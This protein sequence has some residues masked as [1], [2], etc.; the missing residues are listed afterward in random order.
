MEDGTN[1]PVTAANPRG[2]AENVFFDRPRLTVATFNLL[3]FFTTLRVRGAD[4]SEE[5]IRQ[6]DKLAAAIIGL[7]ADILGLVE[8]ENDADDFTIGSLVEVINSVIGDVYTAVETGTIG[9]DAIKVG[10]LYKKTTV[11]EEGLFAI[12]D[13]SVDPR[14]IDTLN[15]PALAQTFKDIVT[16]N[17][18]TVV[19]NHFKAKGSPCS[20][21]PDLQDGQGSCPMT[22]LNAAQ[23][24]VDWIL[25]NPT[26]SPAPENFILLG[27]FNSY[28][29]EP[30]IA[31]VLAVALT[32]KFA[33][34]D[35]NY[36]FRG[37]RGTLDYI[38]VS[39][40]LNTTNVKAWKINADEPVAFDY[41]TEFKSP[42]QLI[43]FYDDSPFRSSDH[44]PLIIGLHLPTFVTTDPPTL[45]TPAPSF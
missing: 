17:F 14:F 24:E 23:A 44:D 30:P 12:L 15:R 10:F 9:T 1:H 43:S 20:G 21:D 41:N 40:N 2:T 7:D 18:I 33:P 42:N 16:G 6:V 4:S 38:F 5:F 31:N 3:N 22:R 35:Y 8:I 13:S 37:F 28:A 25:T 11:A 26:N 39:K 32:D 29:M 34:F 27:D 36:I 19:V 45:A